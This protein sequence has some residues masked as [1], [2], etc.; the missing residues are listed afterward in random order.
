MRKDST[1]H[2]MNGGYEDLNI[3]CCE[4]IPPPHQ[5]DYGYHFTTERSPY[6]D[7][8]RE[9]V[10]VGWYNLVRR[11]DDWIMFWMYIWPEHQ[12]F[13]D[14]SWKPTS[15]VPG[16]EQQCI[17]PKSEKIT[18]VQLCKYC[19]QGYVMIHKSSSYKCFCKCIYKW[20]IT[21]GKY[22]LTDQ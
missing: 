19:K 15:S 5:R 7:Y 18:I 8:H 13:K 1:L 17:T 3:Q 14:T 22:W 9:V 20:L 10:S 12:G 4:S 6:V 11:N 2:S 16:T 21:G